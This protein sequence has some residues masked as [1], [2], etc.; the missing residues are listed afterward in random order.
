MDYKTLI[1]E[2]IGNS[3]KFPYMYESIRESI[4]AYLGGPYCCY[5]A[6]EGRL[7]TE[8]IYVPFGKNTGAHFYMNVSEP[9][10]S[11]NQ[12]ELTKWLLKEACWE[13]F[14]ALAQYGPWY[15][16]EKNQNNLPVWNDDF[17]NHEDNQTLSKIKELF[18][19]RMS[20]KQMRSTIRSAY[21]D[22]RKSSKR[23]LPALKDIKN[24]EDVRRKTLYK[25]QARDMVIHFWF[26]FDDKRVEMAYPAGATENSRR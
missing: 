17:L 21:E 23:Q 11:W 24:V 15:I 25:G 1:E 9:M 2:Y 19:N 12:S 26:D 22:A 4:D 7:L 20:E 3:N 16:P 10:K 5:L 14:A 13:Y 6:D 8:S 18:P